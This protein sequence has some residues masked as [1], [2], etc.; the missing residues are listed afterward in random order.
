MATY[1][2]EKLEQDENRLLELKWGEE[3]SALVANLLVRRLLDK[4]DE[5]L[6]ADDSPGI[7]FRVT[8]TSM[9]TSS[10]PRSNPFPTKQAESHEAVS[11]C[12]GGGSKTPITI[13]E[14]TTQHPVP[15]RSNLEHALRQFR[16]QVPSHK[17]QLFWIDALRINQ[18][19][20]QRKR[21]QN[22]KMSLI[23]N[24]AS[25]VKVWLGNIYEDSY[26]AVSF[27]QK[28]LLLSRLV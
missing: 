21:G 27:I 5:E 26:R 18:G 11:Y 19:N 4:E 8:N 1:T 12:W 20:K 22:K 13:L 6:R 15:I 10:I 23:Y 28:V 2:Y 14:H 7:P 3:G 16:T 24:R 9:E 25:N 17:S